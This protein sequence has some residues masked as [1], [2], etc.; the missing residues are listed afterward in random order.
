MKHEKTVDYALTLVTDRDSSLGRSSLEVVQEAVEGG[1]TLVQLR[2]KAATTRAFY[3]EGW[4]IRGFLRS[5][6]IPLIVNDR[7]DI[8]LVL[9]AEGVHLGQDD[10]PV[11]VARQILGAHRIIGVSVFDAQEAREAE[12]AG[13]DYLGLSPIFL[14]ATKPD[15]SRPIGL[16]GI[17]AIRQSVKIPLVGIGGLDETNA[18]DAVRAG[19]D[20]VAVVSA[21]CS[22]RHPK[23]AARAI[24]GEVRRAKAPERDGDE[25]EGS[26]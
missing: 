9:D 11:P 12:R 1:V 3:D 25:S 20:G 7:I 26:R 19:L 6:G 18:Y 22:R 24:L 16:Q 15:L 8:A 14:T 5:R 17:P 4:R 2:E 23:E 21:V 13:A 10:M